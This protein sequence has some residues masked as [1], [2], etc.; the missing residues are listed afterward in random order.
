MS[1]SH[2]AGLFSFLFW[3]KKKLVLYRVIPLSFQQKIEYRINP[4]L[5]H[6]EV[7]MGRTEKKP[8]GV[9][10]FPFNSAFFFIK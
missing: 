4:S 6:V 1:V 3:K 7:M 8:V 10:S 9:T 2:K 5:P